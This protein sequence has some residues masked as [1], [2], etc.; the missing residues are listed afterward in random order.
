MA[1]TAQA[2]SALDKAL[3]PSPFGRDTANPGVVLSERR[4]L[5]LVQVTAFA[6]PVV[7]N[8]IAA[9]AGV[10]LD[11]RPNRASGGGD[12]QAL[13]LG[14]ERWLVIGPAS[15]SP[16]LGAALAQGLGPDQAAIVELDNARTVIHLSGRNARD[17]L[18]KGCLIDL[19]PKG[20]APGQTAQTAL[21]HVN[22]LIHCVAVNTFDL[23]VTRSHGQS[24]FEALADAAGE[25][26]CQ[27]AG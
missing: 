18:A 20:F 10:T 27:V 26:G 1:S 23:Y 11:E 13:W 6:G 4:G 12:T 7:R 15:R 25:F 2:R 9:M 24:F 17:V 21:F 14:P 8:A 3:L 19:H 5:Y 22:S 16:S